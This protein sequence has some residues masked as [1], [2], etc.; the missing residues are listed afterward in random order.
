MTIARYAPGALVAAVSPRG[1]AVLGEG[2]TDA[3]AIAVWRRLAEGQGL[4][5][6]IDALAAGGPLSSLPAFA[7]AL[8][9]GPVVRV[10]VRGALTATVTTPTGDVTVSGEDTS[11]WA[12][13]SVAEASAV[14]IGSGAVGLPVVDAVVRV[15]ALVIDVAVDAVDVDAPASVSAPPPISAPPPVPVRDEVTPVPVREEATPMPTP[16]PVPV[17]APTPVPVPAPAAAPVDVSVPIEEVPGFPPRDGIPVPE[18]SPDLIDETVI[19][20]RGAAAPVA[21]AA[22]DETV[23][24]SPRAPEP[25]DGDD[26]HTISLAEA[27]ALR[28]D[29]PPPPAPPP[30][31]PVRAPAQL[32]LS[33]GQT[34]LLDRPVV[35]GRRPR[36]TRVAG[37]DL[38]HLVAVPSPQ[39]DISRNHVEVRVEGDSILVTDL[40]TTNGTTLHRSGA[41]PMRLHP[42]EKTVARVGDVLD[43]GDGVIVTVEEA[44]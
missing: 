13:R 18:P 17:P 44:P 29:A 2:A 20:V 30:P 23:V 5:G 7:V 21:E 16:V 25:D 41:D 10:A 40:A 11:T 12:E 28:G 31:A 22:L 8:A 24:S 34:V 33:T 15:A 42:E 1:A 38:P 39:Q 43:L 14:T 35:I 36:S 37:A 6:V 26:D 3:A 19:S 4:G 27:R 9:E 32:V